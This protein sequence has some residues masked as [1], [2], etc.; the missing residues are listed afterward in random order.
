MHV[1]I[2]IKLDSIVS[3]ENSDY[4]AEDVTI[5]SASSDRHTTQS[6]ASKSRSAFLQTCLTV[7]TPSRSLAM[8]L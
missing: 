3:T 7:G 1:N 4:C 5:V 6:M 2:K 8:G